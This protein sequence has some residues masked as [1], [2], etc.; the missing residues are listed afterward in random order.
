MKYPKP[1]M[2]FQELRKVGF[3]VTFLQEAYRAKGQTFA[4]KINPMKPN[5]PIVFETEGFEKWRI[6]R[7]KAENAGIQRK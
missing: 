2:R 4:Q 6:S 7:C 3:S 1:F 5:S